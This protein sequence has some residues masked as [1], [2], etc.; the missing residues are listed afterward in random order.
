MWLSLAEV[1]AIWSTAHR[2]GFSG[3]FGVTFALALFV[4]LVAVFA[5]LGFEHREARA[6]HHAS[7]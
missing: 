3:S 6:M 7:T 1:W 5:T 2:L 4:G